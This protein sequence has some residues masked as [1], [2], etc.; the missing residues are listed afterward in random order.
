MNSLKL[1]R[2]RVELMTKLRQFP[3]RFL[4]KIHK[5]Q[6]KYG[7]RIVKVLGRTYVISKDVFNPR[8][9]CTSKFM[10]KHIN[11]K[12]EDKVLDVGTGSGILAITA[13]KVACKV[14]AIDIN[15]KAVRCV[16]ENVKRNK[17]EN[18]ISVLQGDLFSVLPPKSKF[19]VILFTPPYLEGKTRTVFDLA[20]YD[21]KKSLVKRFF[22]E[23]KKY[24]K[25][26]GYIQ[27]LY[28]SIAEH[29]KVLEI[30]SDF[31]WECRVIGQK[32]GLL[33]T[34]FIYRLTMKH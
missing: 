11:V 14:V 21:P 23:A 16:R 33:E 30:V 25:P 18:V 17:L 7:F 1:F 2:V 15:P 13:A 29:E 27:M 22:K 3:A 19:D 12:P 31:D 26:N 34:I 24:L 9:F 6:Q 20:I 32:R 4:I 10:A 8:F 5:I 28:S